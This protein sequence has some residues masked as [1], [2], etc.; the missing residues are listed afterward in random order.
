[1]QN[2]L[3]SASTSASDIS[4]T[5]NA[6]LTAGGDFVADGYIVGGYIH[7]SGF[8]GPEN[9][10]V[11]LITAVATSQ[12]EVAETLAIESAGVPV[13][14][15]L[16]TVRNGAQ[17]QPDSYTFLKRVG[18]ID[19]LA[20]F[21][22]NG[23]QISQMTFNFA[24]GSILNGTFDLIGFTETVTETEIVG[25]TIVDIPAHALM[26]SVSSITK[27]DIVGLSVTTEFES[28]N[29][30]INNNIN[31]AKAIGTLGAVD[32]ASFTLDVTGDINLYFEDIATYDKFKAA[33]SFSLAITLEDSGG[34]I[35]IVSMPKVKF[36]TLES[37]VDGKDNFLFQAGTMRALRDATNNYMVQFDFFDAP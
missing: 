28:L 25:Q 18:G 3:I 19:N 29:L 22:Y 16:T 17:S 1:M 13:V 9:N 2:D 37:P 27:I 26:N 23:M 6:F 14:I 12:I 5:A 20:Y 31:A 30:T 34:N 4:T 24:T 15:S 21:Y 32:L 8:S 10:G 11:F 33:D 7:V 35:M 36:E